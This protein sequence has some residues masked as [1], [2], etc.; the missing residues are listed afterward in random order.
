MI[1][2]ELALPVRILAPLIPYVAIGIGLLF[3]HNGWIAMLGYHL[4]IIMILLFAGGKIYFKQI[5]KPGS[6][7]IFIAATVMG[8]AGGLLLYLMWPLLG[9]P[10]DIDLYFQNI[11]LTGE[12]WPYFIAY[13]ILVNPWLEEYYWRGYL[14][15]NSKRIILNDLLFA[16]YHILVLMK[17]VDIVW[18]IAVFI[19][20]SLSAWLWRQ[21]DR[22]NQ[23]LITSIVSHAAADISVILTIYFMATGI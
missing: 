17:N 10:G 4:S 2:K 7:A 3:L 18:L 13:F 19:V 9:I 16:G 11:G 20:L 12:T 21:A 23:G 22:L 1:K 14:G 8:V 15:S 5:N 6:Y